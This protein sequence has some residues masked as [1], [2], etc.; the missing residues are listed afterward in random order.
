MKKI[1]T[2]G[3]V[4]IFVLTPVFSFGEELPVVEFKKKCEE[5]I[6]LVL[7]TDAPL[8]QKTILKKSDEM[9]A[10]GIDIA[11]R[12]AES[13][14][15]CKPILDVFIQEKENMKKESLADFETLYHDAGI[16]RKKGLNIDPDDYELEECMEIS[17]MLTHPAA[18][19]VLL[20]QYN[21]DKNT[22]HLEKIKSELVKLSHHLE[23][24]HHHHKVHDHTD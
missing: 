17:H 20:G 9:M 10:L 23:E 13:H 1:L 15:E 5:V 14:S 8:D 16:F 12:Y 22:A 4:A 6:D 18:I 19:G 7:V 11:N 24:H 21:K 2:I 3:I